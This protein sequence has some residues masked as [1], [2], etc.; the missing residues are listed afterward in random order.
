[1]AKNVNM[2]VIRKYVEYI[3]ISTTEF[4]N[5]VDVHGLLEVTKVVDGMSV[6]RSIKY[7]Y[8]STG[9]RVYRC[10]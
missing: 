1:M 10:E 6:G 2:R 3:N 9:N 4:C 8:L 5:H 7:W